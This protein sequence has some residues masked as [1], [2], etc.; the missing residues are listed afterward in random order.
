LRVRMANTFPVA[1]DTSVIAHIGDAVGPDAT[2]EHLVTL[3]AN[4]ARWENFFVDAPTVVDVTRVHFG[5][6]IDP[7][8]I[9]TGTD[10]ALCVQFNNGSGVMGSLPIQQT[11]ALRVVYQRI[12]HLIDQGDDPFILTNDEAVAEAAAADNRIRGFFPTADYAGVVDPIALLNPAFPVQD[13]AFGPWTEILALS[14]AAALDGLDRVVGLVP[15]GWV[16]ERGWVLLP[17]GRNGVSNDKVAPHFVY[18]EAGRNGSVPTHELGHTFGLSDEPCDLHGLEA[19]QPWLCEDEYNEEVFPN[20]PFTGKGFD[21][22]NRQE[23]PVNPDDEVP[24]FMGSARRGPVWISNTDFESL[25]GRM[26]PG[27]DPRVLVV[28]GVVTAAGGGELLAAIGRPEGVPDRLSRHGSP[29]ALVVRDTNG[30]ALGEYGILTDI[31]GSDGNDRNHNGVFDAN[32]IDGDLD[33]NGIPDSFAIPH[34]FNGKDRAEFSLRIPW[35]AGGTSVALIGPNGAVIDSLEVAEAPLALELLE[36]VGEVELTPG[37]LLPIRWRRPGAGGA[38]A[39]AQGVS[40][41]I[42]YDGGHTFLPRAHRVQGNVFVLDARS[43]ATPVMVKVQV[44]ALQNGMAGSATSAP[45]S[46]QDGCPDPIDPAPVVRNTLDTDRDG[47]PDVCDRCPRVPDR[48]QTDADHDGQGDACDADYN[49]DGQV[50][51]DDFTQGFVPCVG[52]DVVARPECFDKDRNRDGTVTPDD[53]CFG[54][55]CDDG[56]PCNGTETCSTQTGCLPG[57]PVCSPTP[58]RTPTPS[59][60]PVPTGMQM[61]FACLPAVADA[62]VSESDPNA[63]YGDSVWL[64]VGDS[65]AEFLLRQRSLVKF[66]LA[67]AGLPADATIVDARFEAYLGGADGEANATIDLYDVNPD[68]TEN[69]VTWNNRPLITTQIATANVGLLVNQYV[70]WE[71]EDLTALVDGWSQHTTPNRG[72]MLRHRY[73]NGAYTGRTFRSRET[74]SDPRLIVTYT[75]Q[76]PGVSDVPC[77]D[78]SSDSQPPSLRA[79][80]APAA[81]T[82]RLALTITA[83]ADD[84]SGIQSVDIYFDGS[85]AQSCG[86]AGARHVQCAY[87]TIP[88]AGLHRYYTLAYDMAGNGSSTPAVQVRA[89]VDG[90][91]P[92]VTVTHSPRNPAAGEAIHFTVTA[93]DDAGLQTVRL[94]YAGAERVWLP[95]GDTMIN[96]ELEWTPP[97]GTWRATY[98]ASARDEEDFSAFT[99]QKT[100]LIGNDGADRDND[101]LSDAMEERLC[102]DPDNPDSDHDAL[103]DGWELLGQPFSDGTVLDLPGM[104]AGP[105]RRDLFLELDWEN[106][107][108]PPADAVQMLVNAY[109]DHGI[110]LHVD[111]GQWGDGGDAF[112]V[113]LYEDVRQAREPNSDA[114]RLWTFHYAFVR[115][116]DPGGTSGHCCSTNLNI[117]VGPNP[118][119]FE[120]AKEIMHELGHSAGLG[121]G[122]RTEA[123]TQLRD[124]NFIYYSG[125]WDSSN[126]TPNHRGSMNYGYYAEIYWDPANL[127]WVKFTGYSQAALPTLDERHLDERP[128]SAFA[129]ALPAYPAPP[130]LVPVVF[131]SCLDPDDDIA[132]TMASD[133]TQTLARKRSGS[134]WQTADL[135]AHAP[136]I[137]WNCDGQIAA[138]VAANINGDGAKTWRPTD[139]PDPAQT[140]V[141]RED[142]SLI[143]WMNNCPGDDYYSA[144]YL[145]LADNPPC[146]GGNGGSASDGNEPHTD[147]TD[148]LDVN[149]LPA[150]ACDGMDNNGDTRTDEGCPDRDGDQIVD[151]IDN[152]PDVPNADQADLDH[153]HTGD[154]CEEQKPLALACTGDCNKGGTVSIDEL[155]RGVNIALDIQSFGQCAPFDVDGNGGVTIDELLQ[156]VNNALQGCS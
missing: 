121:H 22:P 105:C 2:D 92:R 142:W 36:P 35:P 18:A 59:P 97:A 26:A 16:D 126:F 80:H 54:N 140:F 46:D 135:P 61:R 101:G 79:S 40:I 129:E 23:V 29:L 155:V 90:Q 115:N 112:P 133:G 11:R 87:E 119:A 45:D 20:G 134:G 3:Q 37:D 4:E 103:L 57:I 50:N 150:E 39:D 15:E 38:A 125:A 48:L 78:A 6:I 83:V 154:V 149:D 28:S 62:Y 141:G 52:A 77:P 42:S 138:D 21:V 66:D 30:A 44:L 151:A 70:G 13:F 124:G 56:N 12:Y 75:T 9:L 95:E 72:F 24:C 144:A 120:A 152:C 139:W 107:Y 47:V 5:A 49:N 43:L 147:P 104:G 156:G 7:L 117:K 64:A 81:V 89:T 86:F 19:L 10:A 67:A 65:D 55:P 127:T 27:A 109:G 94:R 93:E 69:V 53:F 84:A 34:S 63:N 113:G 106:G 32:E 153:N 137:D 100:V 8:G 73:E 128:T 99:P 71:S 96:E 33:G 60:T 130:G 143:P 51:N 98:S 82:T 108:A 102:T 14:E 68:W 74:N 85:R 132:Y 116:R 91:A 146:P 136:G 131:Y 25:V 88:T 122:G 17:E 31:T 58:T 76:H 111:T 41:A 1:V 118:S 148:D 114:H 145:A 110:R 123:A